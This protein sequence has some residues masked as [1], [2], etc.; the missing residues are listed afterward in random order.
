MIKKAQIHFVC[1]VMSILLGFFSV[2]FFASY[3]VLKNVNDNAIERI[4]DNVAYN[5]TTLGQEFVQEKGLICEFEVNE[6]K[7]IT[8][9]REWYDT[10]FFSAEQ[11]NKIIYTAIEDRPYKAGSIDN[12]YYKIIKYENTNLLIAGDMTE[13]LQIFKSNVLTSFFAVVGVF[14]CLSFIVWALSF[15]VFSPIKEAFDKQKQFVSDASHELKTP[16]AIITANADVLSSNEEN[17]QWVKNIKTQTNRMDTLIA[18]MLTLAKMDENTKTKLKI[19]EFSLSDEIISTTLPF[20]A[21]A[22]E[23]GKFLDIDVDNNIN[24]KGD[25]QS[26]KQILSI[27]L[28]NAVKH[29][30]N[31]GNILVSLK[32]ENGKNVV[33]T[34]RN[35]GSLVPDKDS[36]KI[37]ERFY[38]IDSS[39]AR[40]TGGSGLGL[41]IAKG[42]A[43]RNNWKITAQSE[44]NVSMTI[45]IIF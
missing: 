44:Y 13:S 19:E 28:D 36:N 43:D 2:L 20:D 23:R 6:N 15:R 7:N 3:I 24:Y 41:S 14:I 26:V 27:L 30:S 34:V 35:S 37:F 32:K 45:K 18:D 16:V 9:H 25:R 4:L 5:F 10:T 38:R 8:Y 12:V 29:A 1:I 17:E 11:V 39:R 33:L 21:V 40:D 22:F 42:I 31:E